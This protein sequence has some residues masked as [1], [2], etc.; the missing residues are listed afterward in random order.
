LWSDGISNLQVGASMASVLYSGNSAGGG[1]QALRF[2]ERPEIRVD[3]TRLID[4]GNIA[5]KTGDMIALDM[6]GNFQ[7]FYLEGE[8]AQYKMDRQC[9]ATVSAICTSSQAVID[10]PVFHGWTVGGSWIITGET[11]TYTPAGI[12][13]TQAGFG[14]PVP[15]RPFSLIGGSW[16]AWELAARYSNTNLNWNTAQLA[17]A[18]LGQQAG[19]LGGRQRIVALGVNWYLN[20][21]IRIML[22]DNIVSISRGTAALP[23]RDN[24][25]FN[26]L[27]LR[28]QYSN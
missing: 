26:V 10:H 3:G 19:V 20:R 7:N 5:A 14:A 18:A 21:N 6:E 28:F 11:K 1:A 25:D 16:G 23:N 15:S 12:A 2:R 9:G 8:W 27:G 17:S 13:E 4:T 22:D 24:Q